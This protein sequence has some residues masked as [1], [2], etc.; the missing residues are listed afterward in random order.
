[1]LCIPS[2][3]AEPRLSVLLL[4]SLP[5]S[6]SRRECWKDGSSVSFSAWSSGR[7][8]SLSISSKASQ[9]P[10]K[11][12]KYAADLNRKK[13]LTVQIGMKVKIKAPKLIFWEANPCALAL[14]EHGEASRST[15]SLSSPKAVDVEAAVVGFTPSVM[16][17]P[18]APL[19]CRSSGSLKL[20]CS[21]RSWSEAE[22]GARSLWGR[23]RG[24]TGSCPR[25][26]SK[27]LASHYQSLTEFLTG[28][29]SLHLHYYKISFASLQ[30]I[31]KYIYT[32]LVKMFK[33]F[34]YFFNHKH[35]L[36]LVLQ[37]ALIFHF[38]L[39]KKKKKQFWSSYIFDLFSSVFCFS[40]QVLRIAIF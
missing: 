29:R 21:V 14:E 28:Q 34:K 2:A 3:A 36:Q 33:S 30:Q 27:S 19:L 31:Y 11:R 32:T 24:L 15:R 26:W 1:M 22:A 16:L 23:G 5:C 25:C 37:P 17:S 40:N 7:Y 8:F 12:V 18:A 9:V 20:L 4:R 39:I 35:K 38:C 6:S 13:L 10:N